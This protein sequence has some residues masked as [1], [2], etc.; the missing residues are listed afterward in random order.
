[1]CIIMQLFCYAPP[2]GNGHIADVNVAVGLLSLSNLS[3][4]HTADTLFT[5]LTLYHHI[6]VVNTKLLVFSFVLKYFR[7]DKK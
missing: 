7:F 5:G 2:P 4:F 3:Y 6:T 1:M